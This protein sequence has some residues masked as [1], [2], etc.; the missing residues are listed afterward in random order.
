M[1]FVEAAKRAKIKR[2]LAFYYYSKFRNEAAAPR[3]KRECRFARWYGWPGPYEGPVWIGTRIS[4]P[5]TWQELALMEK[6]A[7]E[8][9]RMA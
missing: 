7:D 6:T 2:S 9:A 3:Q 1:K 8:L 4:P 5:L